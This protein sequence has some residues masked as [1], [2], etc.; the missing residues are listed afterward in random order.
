M[1][2]H[3]L[4]YIQYGTLMIYTHLKGQ[5]RNKTSIYQQVCH[6]WIA[7]GSQYIFALTQ[8]FGQ[9]STSVLGVDNPVVVFQCVHDLKYSAH[10]AN[11]VV[12]GHCADELCCQVCVQCQLNL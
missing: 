10:P 1:C 11:G 3:I 7:L 6:Y 9:D 12:D 2:L 5:N 4:V 8:T